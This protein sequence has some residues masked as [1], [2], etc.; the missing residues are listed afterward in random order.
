MPFDGSGSIEAM[1]LDRLNDARRQI[2]QGWCQGSF[3]NVR[4][5]ILPSEIPILSFM[6]DKV[7]PPSVSIQYETYEAVCIIGAVGVRRG[8]VPDLIGEKA[9]ETIIEV[10]RAHY[11]TP[12]VVRWNDYPHREKR[13]VLRLF[14]LAI[15]AQ[16]AKLSDNVV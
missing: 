2:E 6:P 14:D 10:L 13:E 1:T 5:R 4:R 9:I 3:A 12:H 11:N 7:I 15:E 16:A 8:K